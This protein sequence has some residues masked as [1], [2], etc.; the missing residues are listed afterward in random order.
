MNSLTLYICICIH[1]CVCMYIH[2]H[3][4][5][6]MCPCLG[7]WPQCPLV[8][9]TQRYN[10]AYK[11]TYDKREINSRRRNR[12]SEKR[13]RVTERTC[14]PPK[15]N[16]HIKTNVQS[17]SMTTFDW[18]LEYVHVVVQGKPIVH[19]CPLTSTYTPCHRYASTHAHTHLHTY[20]MITKCNIY[21]KS[22]L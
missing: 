12:V 9:I 3:T 1:I 8:N 17:A 20:T 22:Y 5:V 6:L 4:H 2:T 14:I 19:S 15:K 11:N 13:H 18:L 7:I 10:V 16:L 21:V